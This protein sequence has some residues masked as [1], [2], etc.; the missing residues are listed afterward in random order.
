DEETIFIPTETSISYFSKGIISSFEESDV[1]I[2]FYTNK[3]WKAAI[4]YTDDTNNWI[5]LSK[6]SGKG[7]DIFITLNFSENT[8]TKNRT[9]VLSIAVG[10]NYEYINIEQT[11]NSNGV[12]DVKTPGTLAD[13]LPIE[14]RPYIT[15]LTI[16]GK[17]NG[18][19]IKIIR[20]LFWHNNNPQLQKLDLSEATIVS[21]GDPYDSFYQVHTSDYTI[22]P[23]MFMDYQG[24]VLIIPRNTKIIDYSS[25]Y[26][27]PNISELT[28]PAGVEYIHYEAFI[29]LLSL[30]KL[31][32][33]ANVKP[34][35]DRKGLS[36]QGFSELET[37][38]S[39]SPYLDITIVLCDKLKNLELYGGISTIC[40]L[41]SLSSV[42]LHDGITEIGSQAFIDCPSLQSIIIPESVKKISNIAFCYLT[43]TSEVVFS[44]NEIHYKGST[45][46]WEADL[47]VCPPYGLSNCILYVPKASLSN[48]ATLSS[49]FKEI[50]G[51]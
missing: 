5:T 34:L 50:R 9:A 29:R 20:S 19:D 7:G 26:S 11:S 27:L 21:G 42:I 32:I 12:I 28:I 16:K 33:P 24:T 6:S 2:E 49:Y 17:L 37:F 3:S 30:K 23:F 51:E 36:I 48:F 46:P 14:A 4:T 18:T 45:S 15:E 25:F 13:F 43:S 47:F 10:G 41:P 39:L 38:V 8:T 35:D 1:S 22:S 31:I 40:S 44:L